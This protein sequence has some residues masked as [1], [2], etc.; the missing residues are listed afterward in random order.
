MPTFQPLPHPV[1]LPELE[2]ATLAFWDERQIFA[3]SLERNRQGKPFVFYEG[4]PTANGTP[5]VHHVLARAFKDC[6]LRFQQL[7][8]R[9]VERRGGWDTHGLP[10]ELEV[11][12]A[13]GIRF[14]QEIEQLGVAE[15]NRLCRASVMEYI[16]EW[17]RFTS[18]IGF[19]VDMEHAYRTYD[20]QY[21]ESVWWSLKQIYESG[22]LYRGYRVAPYCPRC[23]TSL[24]SHELGLPG[25]YRDN[26]PDPGVTIRFR[27]LEEPETSVLAWT[28]TPWTL[29]GNLALAVGEDIVYVKV[30][31]GRERLIL[32]RD[33]L[34]LLGGEYEV[35]A[36]VRGADLVGLR[37]Q[38]LFPYLPEQEQAWSI[39]AAD[40]VSTEEGTGVVHTAGAY[41][42]DDLRLCQE[43]G[44]EVRHT[45]GPDGR[46]LPFV[47]DFAGVFFKEADPAIIENLKERGLLYR[48]E[49][50]LHSYPF[51]WRCETPL[52][53]Y[54]LNSWFI[55]TTAVQEPLL[56]H[57]RSVRWVPAHLRDGRMGNWLETLQD[58]NLSRARYWGTPLPIWECPGC[59]RERCVGSLAELGL[60]PGTDVHKPF[61]DTVTLPCECGREMHR[62]PEVIDC[63]YDSGAVPY[64]QWHY[65]F[66]NRERFEAEHPAHFISEAVDQ[67]RGWFYTLLAES[68]MLFDKPAYRAVVV[69]NL[70]VDEQGRK[71]S[72]SRG[73]VVDPWELMGAT[74]ADALRWWFYTT[75]TVGLEYRIS[76]RRVA[77]SATKFVNL[78]WNTLSFLVTYANLAEWRPGTG[79]DPEP[80]ARHVLDRWIL[81]R[82]EATSAEVVESM[83]RFDAH[84]ACR[85][86]AVLIDDTSTWYL[87][88]SRSR[89]RA[90]A[91]DSGSAFATL[92]EVLRQAARL[93]APFTP[94]L[95]DAIYRE[96]S[97][98]LAGEPESVH[99]DHLPQHRPELV[100]ADLLRGME[101][102]RRLAE[103]A[104]SERERE[105]VAIRQPL[106][107]A[108]VSGTVLS[109]ELAQV[110]A[111]EANVLEVVADPAVEPGRPSLRLDSVLTPALRREG[112]LRSVSRQIQDARKKAGFTPGE[113]ADLV[114]WAGG[115]LQSVLESGVERLQAQCFLRRVVRSQDETRP[116][117]AIS[118]KVPGQD[119]WVALRPAQPE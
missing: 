118:L 110:L 36:E 15:F 5:G 8:G 90:E 86:I 98:P 106:A 58:W 68:V 34:E 39:L 56:R 9:R 48:S 47:A 54:A 26:T 119:A 27:L 60:P 52:I 45:V 37:Y 17:E 14:K 20:P 35:E 108:F 67:T 111:E 22:W 88:R 70:L 51:C 40:F 3:K 18:R 13:L 73:N 25:G 12:R 42:E 105:G 107:R 1:R 114:W 38:R 109:P 87:R 62:V 93:L 99:L 89:F 92:F 16:D 83:E 6:F 4:P 91:E 7:R 64:A 59:Q 69:P 31:Q 115:E 117:D 66:E 79:A 2:E 44:L 76:A 78:V 49:P 41:G 112:M 63:W 55:R 85:A 19:W 75:V 29:P 23:Q 103:D 95:A 104:R 43:A 46:F 80:A 113:P 21:M 97:A 11:E 72:K 33:R 57:N 71:M 82:L 84:S 24:S 94:F 96:L 30:R 65:P 53:Y 28:T 74:G 77:E 61:I 32:A 81:A 100:D 116:P 10:V 102:V 50:V 101:V